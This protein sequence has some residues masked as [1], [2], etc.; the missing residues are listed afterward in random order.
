ML[1]HNATI[2]GQALERARD[3]LLEVIEGAISDLQILQNRAPSLEVVGKATRPLEVVPRG[4]V[5][6]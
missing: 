3:N 4:G 1:L 6:T 5:L 2:E